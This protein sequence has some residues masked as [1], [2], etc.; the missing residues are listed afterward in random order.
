MPNVC[1]D[2]F[3]LFV[4]TKSIKLFNRFFKV[5]WTLFCSFIFIT[6]S[7]SQLKVTIENH[8]TNS[9]SVFMPFFLVCNWKMRNHQQW[10]KIAIFDVTFNSLLLHFCFGCRHKENL[11]VSQVQCGAKNKKK[12][13]CMPKYFKFVRYLRRKCYNNKSKV[14]WCWC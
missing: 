8:I 1:D 4:P 2:Q 5:Y 14:C 3:L 13:N 7:R 9:C 11:M 10:T 12:R 6:T